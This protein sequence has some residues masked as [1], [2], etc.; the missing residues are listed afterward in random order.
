VSA[1]I[2]RTS[3]IPVVLA[4]GLRPDNV[5]E[6]VRTVRPWAVNVNS[7]VERDGAKNPRLIRR[8]TQ[9]ANT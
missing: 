7:G 6:A 2:V 8:L 4:G 1:A 9:N 3:P 5:Q